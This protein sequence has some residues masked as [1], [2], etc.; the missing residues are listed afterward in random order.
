L[1]AYGWRLS[2]AVM[3]S[4]TVLA[5]LDLARD[6]CVPPNQRLKLTPPI[7]LEYQ[8]WTI[9]ERPLIL[10]TG[11]TPPPFESAAPGPWYVLL[12]GN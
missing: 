8:R 10:M 3:V 9:G 5:A 2:A 7:T 1:F 11:R 4:G 6:R 12:Q